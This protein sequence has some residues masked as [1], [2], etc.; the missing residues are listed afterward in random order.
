M[1]FFDHLPEPVLALLTRVTPVATQNN[2]AITVYVSL[3]NRDIRYRP[4]MFVKALLALRKQPDLLLVPNTAI[5]EQ[6]G[7]RLVY[8][9]N[10]QQKIEPR[11]VRLG[12]SG[13]IEF[14]PNQPIWVELLEGVKLGDRVII[15]DLGSLPE[16]RK[17]S[18][19]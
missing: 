11:K 15:K 6:L 13:F 7:E 19:E 9:V 1:L 16:G 2:R 3:D 18:V 10:E 17:V 12:R 4:G 14:A 8:M 5:R